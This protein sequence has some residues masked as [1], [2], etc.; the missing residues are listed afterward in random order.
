MPP[1]NLLL[2]EEESSIEKDNEHQEPMKRGQLSKR[3]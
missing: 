1:P 2:V 3:E